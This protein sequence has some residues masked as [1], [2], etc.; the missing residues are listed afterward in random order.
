MGCHWACDAWPIQFALRGSPLRIGRLCRDLMDGDVQALHIELAPNGSLATTYIS[1][2]SEMG[3]LGGLLGW[4]AYDERLPG[5]QRYILEAGIAV[6]L[7]IADIN[8][9]HPGTPTSLP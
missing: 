5:Y 4:E 3:L 9:S 1:Q 7:D 6:T 2:G 8:A